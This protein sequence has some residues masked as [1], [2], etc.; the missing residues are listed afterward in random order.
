MKAFNEFPKKGRFV[1]A[2]QIVWVSIL[3][4]GTTIEMAKLDLDLVESS[5]GDWKFLCIPFWGQSMI[6]L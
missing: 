3:H 4:I 6:L 5:K 2:P 1:M